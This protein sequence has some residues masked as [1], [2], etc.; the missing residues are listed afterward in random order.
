MIF[1]IKINWNNRKPSL[2]TDGNMIKSKNNTCNKNSLRNTV[3]S[4]LLNNSNSLTNSKN[5]SAILDNVKEFQGD[6]NTKS[7]QKANKRIEKYKRI[8]III[9]LMS[10]TI[11][12]TI[13]SR[14]IFP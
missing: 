13:I 12:A 11:M 6:N 3:E 4:V 1:Q 5:K 2:N 14:I 9:F 7:T 10:K 8:I